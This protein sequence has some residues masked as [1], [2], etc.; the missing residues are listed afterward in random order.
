MDQDSAGS[1]MNDGEEERRLC[2]LA[3][4]VESSDD[5]IVGM[6]CEGGILTWNRGA[7][8][9]LG[10]AEWEA[11]GQPV[12][13]LFADDAQHQL[14]GLLQAVNQGE[15]VRQRQF[16]WVTSSGSHVEVAVTVSP[17]RDRTGAIVGASVTGRDVSEQRWMAATLDDAIAKLGTALAD[18]QEAESRGR[19][20]LADAAHQLRGPMA[21]IRANAESIL[22]GLE[23]ED[24]DRLLR[25]LVREVAR[26]DR[27]ISALL[28]MARLDQGQE[29]V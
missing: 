3:A 17:V 13:L 6:S 27:L 18:A 19:R 2:L 20:F 16:A 10:Y 21:A 22:E 4:I 5:A 15:R 1:P 11:V 7:M 24:R 9:M 25:N 8:E 12:S 26:S 28:K 14:P 23:E 29:V